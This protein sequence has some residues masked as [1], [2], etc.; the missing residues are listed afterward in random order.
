MTVKQLINKLEQFD[1]NMEVV[2][3]HRDGGGEYYGADKDVYICQASVSGE[4]YDSYNRVI[5]GDNDAGKKVVVV[6]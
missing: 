1:D 4:G 3:H 5:Y 6:L 2:V